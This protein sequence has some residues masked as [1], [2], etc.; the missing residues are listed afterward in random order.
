MNLKEDLANQPEEVRTQ[1]L[2]KIPKA[3]QNVMN[4]IEDAIAIGSERAKEEGLI[5][6][7]VNN[8]FGV[9][10]GKMA[11]KDVQDHQMRDLAR[12]CEARMAC[13]GWLVGRSDFEYK[14]GE[15]PFINP[16]GSIW[17]PEE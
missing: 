9:Y 12:V 8:D 5:T 14:E 7:I 2:K 15:V 6:Q 16:M 1:Q 10:D 11:Y 3:L 13:L 17:A 4:Q